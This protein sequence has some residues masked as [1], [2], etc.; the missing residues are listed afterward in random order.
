M[1]RSEYNAMHAIKRFKER[2]EL[3]M[4]VKLYEAM[5]EAI[6]ADDKRNGKKITVKKIAQTT[7]RRSVYCIRYK[8]KDV[9]AVY[10]SSTHKLVTFLPPDTRLEVYIEREKRRRL[11][12]V[13][14]VTA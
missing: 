7:N 6:R 1:K 14:T 13:D 10:S 4:S 3:P 11:T 2:Y 8:N 9:I 12:H 5:E